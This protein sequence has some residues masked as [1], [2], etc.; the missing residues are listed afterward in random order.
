MKLRKKYIIPTALILALLGGG[1]G[2][3]L[4]RSS[5]RCRAGRLL[6]AVS[7]LPAEPG[8]V[9]RWLEALGLKKPS[10]EAEAKIVVKALIS[11]GP[12][13]APYLIDALDD[14]RLEARIVAIEALG[15]IGDHRAVELLRG[16]LGGQHRGTALDPS[17]VFGT[18]AIGAADN[19]SP[20]AMARD[21]G[22][23]TLLRPDVD[24]TGTVRLASIRALGRIG[25]AR[26]AA[27]LADLLC[28]FAPLLNTR[29]GWP[30]PIRKLSADEP[31]D[32]LEEQAGMLLS[33]PDTAFGYGHEINESA[34]AL[35]CIGV[36]AVEALVGKLRQEH[37]RAREAAVRVMVGIGDVRTVESLIDCL[38][39]RSSVVAH[40]AVIGLGKIGGARAAEALRK[41]L[42]GQPRIS[43][44]AAE[45]ALD[46]IERRLHEQGVSRSQPANRQS[47]IE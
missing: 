21:L 31:V 12:S 41:F 16:M 40:A 43:V 23:P 14:E 44:E 18:R 47:S 15:R 17:P 11:L 29:F 3:R 32:V 8:R 25:D 9:D 10:P 1:I 19:Y 35:V 6:S 26:A 46:A 45:E 22:G 4:Y 34:Q 37:Y 42:A 27:P 33:Y 30:E 2:Y 24:M 7:E 20:Y 28:M 13:A 39:D 38:D 5:A 36:P